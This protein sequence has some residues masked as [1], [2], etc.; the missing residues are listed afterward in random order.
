MIRGHFLIAPAALASALILFA[1]AALR[2]GD[3]IADGKSG[4]KIWNPNPTLGE[5]ANWTGPCKDGFAEGEGVL[6]WLRGGSRFER[7]EGS[8]HAGRQI[9]AGTQTW[10]QGQYKGQFAGSLPEGSGTLT[11][12]ERRYEGGFSSGKPEGN[13]T[14]TEPSGTINGTWHSGCFNDG[15]RRAAIGATLQSCP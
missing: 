5:S 1:P 2:A 7:D 15:A 13:G 4:C 8:W 3:W 11:L 6:D 10:P 12:G 14:L 9:G